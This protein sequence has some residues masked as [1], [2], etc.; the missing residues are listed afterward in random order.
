MKRT[1]FALLLSTLLACSVDNTVAGNNRTP[2]EQLAAE[3]DARCTSI[4]NWATKCP[5]PACDCVGDQCGCAQPIDAATCPADCV[6][7]LS[8]YEGQG[9]T[10]A[11]AGLGILTC[12]AGAS[13][14][15]IYQSDLCQPSDAIRSACAQDGTSST[16]P[17]SDVGSSGVAGSAATGSNGGAAGTGASVTCQVGYGTGAAGSGNTPAAGY[18]SCEQGFDSCSDGHSYESLC[19]VSDQNAFVCSCLVDNM[20][21]SSFTPAVMCPAL[22]EINARCGWPL[23]LH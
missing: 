4:C 5:A 12:L 20:L 17:S 9:D 3:I 7:S 1:A 15:S 22:S 2:E 8:R 23:V 13:C 19:V 16:A 10:C 11:N 21:Q 6:K 18:V 14:A